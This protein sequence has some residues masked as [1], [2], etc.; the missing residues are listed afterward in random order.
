MKPITNIWLTHAFKGY[1]K[2]LHNVHCWV[3]I[4]IK[5]HTL[6]SNNYYGREKKTK[7]LLA[8]EKNESN[9]IKFNRNTKNQMP[10]MYPNSLMWDFNFWKYKHII[11]GI[12]LVNRRGFSISNIQ[13]LFMYEFFDISDVYIWDIYLLYWKWERFLI[14]HFP[15]QVRNQLNCYQV[16]LLIDW[17]EAFEKKLFWGGEKNSR[18][19]PINQSFYSYVHCTMYTCIYVNKSEEKFYTIDTEFCTNWIFIGKTLW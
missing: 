15:F 17:N 7:N 18:T 19:F 3:H 16:L 12:N 8:V 4:Q 14:F 13:N 1:N 9:I 5:L 10:Y 11:Y 6:K 2:W